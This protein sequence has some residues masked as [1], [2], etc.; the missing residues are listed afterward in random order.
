[1]IIQPYLIH[2]SESSVQPRKRENGAD[3]HK[4]PDYALG[5]TDRDLAGHCRFL[6]L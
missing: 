1:M 2:N 5:G 4:A 6:S 3:G